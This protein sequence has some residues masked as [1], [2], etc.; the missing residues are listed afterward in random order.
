MTTRG[1]TLVELLVALAIT[2]LLAGAL[3]AIMPG[4]RAAFE[5]IPADLELHQRGR[6]AIETLTQV[7]RAAHHVSLDSP[8]DDGTFA[9]LTAVGAVENPA[10]GALS[11][12]QASPGAMITLGV[13]VCP[14]VSDVCG[15]KAGDVAMISDQDGGFD[16]FIVAALDVVLRRLTPDRVLSHVYPAGS[17]VVEVEQ[18]TFSLD[19]QPDGSYSLIRVTAAGAVQPIVD[20]IPALA[21]WADGHSIGVR[22]TAEAVTESERRLVGK[23]TFQT[24][25]HVRSVS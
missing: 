22:L 17:K 21:F 3:L 7:L 18:Q 8:D 12:D 1:F 13:D 4:A 11:I 23:R 25:I 5:R 6:I 9:Q 10:Q 20:F 16:V 15:F 14:D 2:L 24:S 19:L